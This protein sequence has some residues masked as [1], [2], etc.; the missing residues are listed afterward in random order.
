MEASRILMSVKAEGTVSYQ[1]LT[2]R[3]LATMQETVAL[4]APECPSR[5]ASGPR[6]WS[7]SIAPEALPDARV[8]GPFLV[9]D[10]GDH[11]EQG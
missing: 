10:A 5:E 3:S 9:G 8:V 2:R 7:T 11:L 4:S 1:D 6:D